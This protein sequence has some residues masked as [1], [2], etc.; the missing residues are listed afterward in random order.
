M[1]ISPLS[2]S[3]VPGVATTVGGGRATAAIGAEDAAIRYESVR[4]SM[5]R[6]MTVHAGKAPHDLSSQKNV[7]IETVFGK[8]RAFN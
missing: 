7:G 5:I 1:A 4:C 2:S 3:D 8:S 6:L